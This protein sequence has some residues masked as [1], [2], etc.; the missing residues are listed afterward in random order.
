MDEFAAA[1]V[2]ADMGDASSPRRVAEK[3]QIARTQLPLGHGRAHAEKF[4]RC[5]RCSDAMTT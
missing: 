4:R 1:D 3:D 2:D 5:P